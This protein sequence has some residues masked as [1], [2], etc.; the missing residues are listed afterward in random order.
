MALTQK[1]FSPETLKGLAL[2]ELQDAVDAL[3]A[4]AVTLA[5]VLAAGAD[6]EKTT[7][8]GLALLRGEQIAGFA[9]LLHIIG[10]ISS[11]GVTVEGG[12]GTG[13]GHGG[14]K[15]SVI[16]GA[17]GVNGVIP[18]VLI[19]GGT[20]PTIG[21]GG[22][23]DLEGGR[24]AAFGGDGPINVGVVDTGAVNLAGATTPLG[25]HGAAAVTQ[26]TITGS[27]TDGTALAS[28]L[29]ALALRGDIIDSTGP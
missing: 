21:G 23:I 3:Q 13:V 1:A 17:P 28:L 6:A 20:Q 29:T 5:Q 25:M 10:G 22:G 24:E 12:L 8:T 9:E 7:I 18:A 14:G 26:Q 16:G 15:V 2:A 27:R 11:G 4:A 19:K